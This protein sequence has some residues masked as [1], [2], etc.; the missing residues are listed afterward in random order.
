M[1]SRI[2]GKGDILSLIEKAQQQF[3]EK[4]AEEL[5]QKIRK[6]TFTLEDYLEQ[7]SQ[8]KNM[9]SLEQLMG[10]LPG[11]KPGAMKDVKIDEKQIDRMEAIIK[12]MTPKERNKPEII[13]ASRKK[14]IAAGSGTRVE[15]VNR[16]LKQF[17]QT[18]KMMKQFAN[19]KGGRG[20]MRFPF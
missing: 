7:F 18:Q 15:E 19:M 14:R 4:K 13:N 6:N 8:I 5:E 2:L 17:E 16:L 11:M 12:S 20:K 9:G 10:M 1:A 3:D